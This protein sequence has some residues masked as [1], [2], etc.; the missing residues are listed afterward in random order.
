[1]TQRAASLSPGLE[2]TAAPLISPSP[3]LSAQR[4]FLALGIVVTAFILVVFFAD[5]VKLEAA[6]PAF[7]AQPLLLVALAVV[8]TGAFW[9]RAVAWQSLLV[10]RSS[11]FHLLVAIQTGLLLN[12]IAPFKLGELVRPVLARRRGVP[13]AEAA[14]T[15]AIARML[16][17]AALLSIAAVVGTA[18][19]LSDGGT[20]WVQ[21][22]VLPAAAVI[23]AGTGF[24]LLRGR[25]TRSWLP[26]RL[27]SR[28]DVFQSQ[29]RQVSARRIACAALWTLPSWVLEASVIIVAAKAMGVELPIAAAVA[30]TAFT[31]LFQA[32]HVTPGGIGVYEAVM[33][34]AL[35]AHGVPAPEGLALA[36]LTHSLKFAYSYTV[37]LAFTLVAV[38]YLPELNP[39]QRLRGNGDGAK[40]ASRFEVLAAR[41]WNVFNEGKPFTP[42]FV[43]GVLALLS[44]SHLSD[45]GYWLKAGISLVAL[46]P[47]FLLFYRFDFPLKLRVALWV[48]LALFLAAFRFVDP[49]AVALVLGLYL[50][51]TVFLWGTVY[52]HLRIG[53]PWTNFTRFWR[54]VLE[55]PDPTSG[56]FLEQIPKALLMVWLSS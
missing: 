35:Y 23:G 31:I 54:L 28:F 38:K 3:A 4:V 20:L 24:M 48:A 14:T 5:W 15:T 9:L 56:N 43:I 10:H 26:S 36:V 55:N 37:A 39:L 18:L 22:L 46:V 7:R 33:T 49:V 42:V 51:F 11:I 40:A 19:S 41:L 17:F 27:R 30:V 52:Y 21:G 44:V 29:L 8:Y 13:M 50:T 32:F 2:A 6:F 12:H 45:G 47:L 53:T 1:M 34:G 25:R 16:D